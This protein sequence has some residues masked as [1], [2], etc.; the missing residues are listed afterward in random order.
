MHLFAA[1]TS[2]SVLANLSTSFTPLEPESF[3]FSSQNSS[4]SVGLDGVQMWTWKSS[5]RF[6]TV[7]RGLCFDL[8]ILTHLFDPNHPNATLAA[9]GFRV[10]VM[11]D[12]EPPLQLQVFCSFSLTLP[13]TCC[14]D[15]QGL[16]AHIN[17]CRR[18]QVVEKTNPTEAVGVVCKVDGHYQV[19]EYSE[20]TLATAEKRSSD[21]RLMFNAGNVAN[22]F[23][24]FSF[25]RDVVQ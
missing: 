4:D 3:I 2:T 20:I 25:L 23:F 19:V 13:L 21:G 11:L 9:G 24:S 5:H 1:D 12:V 22:H 6:S 15:S 10:D 18:F 14:V 17:I 7:C 8:T 16:F